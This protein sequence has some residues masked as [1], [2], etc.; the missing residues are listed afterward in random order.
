MTALVGRHALVTGA[1]RG[2]GAAIARRLSRD[3]ATVTL[4]VRRRGSADAVLQELP[5]G[6]AVVE[7][8]V[9]DAEAVSRACAAAAAIAPI[10]ILVN[11]AGAAESAPFGRTDAALLARMFAVNF[12]GAFAATHAV[13]PAMLAAR[14]GRIVNI[15]STA[16]LTGYPYVSGYVAA[17]HALVGLTRA[18]A[19]EVATRDV[20]V[21]AVCPG[22]TDTDL[23]TASVERI[24]SS[25][26]RS[27]EEARAALLAG[28]PQ[29]RLVQPDEVASA[30][31]WLCRDDAAAVT[32]QAIT[33]AGGELA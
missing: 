29:Q 17:K 3:G 22:F 21:N 23:T 32:G 18:L 2:I 30:V 1:N 6:T 31:A 11:N 24:V 10:D 20:T 16:G 4:L 14:H 13:L 9:T 12:N 27:A 7:A 8:D 19:R 25:T 15:A 28:N 5:G 33:V 26:G